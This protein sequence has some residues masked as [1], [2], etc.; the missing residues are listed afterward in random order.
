M[1]RVLSVDQILR[2][3]F[4]TKI[5]RETH[6]LEHQRSPVTS[7]LKSYAIGQS[8]TDQYICLT[9]IR[10]LPTWSTDSFTTLEENKT[11][12]IC[13]PK[14]KSKKIR[15]KRKKKEEF[16]CEL[17]DAKYIG[18]TW[19]YLHQRVQDQKEKKKTFKDGHNVKPLVNLCE[20]FN[21][22]KGCRGKLK[23]WNFAM[24]KIRQKCPELDTHKTLFARNVSYQL[25]TC[26]YPLWMNEFCQ[27]SISEYIAL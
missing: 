14:F 1:R 7:R 24:L 11:T 18:Y 20:I 10:N 17:W 12:M 8:F 9:R 4:E 3:V 6:R 15:K 19:R 21:I 13:S 26:F 2:D 16:K 23:C 27:N 5:S 25:R 22:P